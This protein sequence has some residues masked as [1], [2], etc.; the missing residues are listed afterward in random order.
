[1]EESERGELMRTL[2]VKWLQS[3]NVEYDELIFA[4]HGKV[5]EC[6]ECNLDVMIEDSAYNME[7]L[8]GIVKKIICFDAPYNKSVQGVIRCKNWNE[9]EKVYE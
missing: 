5:E 7:T 3:N 6:K 2:V 1:M 9:I 4:K 8:K